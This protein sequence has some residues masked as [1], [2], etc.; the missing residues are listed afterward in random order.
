MVVMIMVVVVVL[1]LVLVLVMGQSMDWET[2]GNGGRWGRRRWTVD[3][4][5]GEIETEIV[6][7]VHFFC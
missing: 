7:C 3:V 5:N 4:W 1:L 6:V 2:T